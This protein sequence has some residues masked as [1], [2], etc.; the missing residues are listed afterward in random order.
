[1]TCSSV[2]LSLE[3]HKR[4]LAVSSRS[5]SLGTDLGYCFGSRRENTRFFPRN[6]SRPGGRRC[7]R[8]DD[9]REIERSDAETPR[10][11]EGWELLVHQSSTTRRNASY[12]QLL[13]ILTEL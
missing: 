10:K 13:T 11:V 4:H 1:M 9:E 6:P 7:D 8:Y 2:R 12:F 3:P 5:L